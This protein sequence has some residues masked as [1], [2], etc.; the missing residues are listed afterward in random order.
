MK[1]SSRVDPGRPG[2]GGGAGVSDQSHSGLVRQKYA[3]ALPAVFHRGIS[4]AAL[5]LLSFRLFLC[6][7]FS[8]VSSRFLSSKFSSTLFIPT[9]SAELVSSAAFSQL[10]PRSVPSPTAAVHAPPRGCIPRAL[11]SPT[12]SRGR[13]P[14]Q[15][16]P[17]QPGA[18]MI[19][20]HPG[21]G[22]ESV[23]ACH[24]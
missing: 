13:A 24:G 18:I 4:L 20:W 12:R 6:I 8:T 10:H 1:A 21:R 5:R 14:R 3:V 23:P 16:V 9:C 2:G 11:A 19:Q 7:L 22:S 15:S 17:S